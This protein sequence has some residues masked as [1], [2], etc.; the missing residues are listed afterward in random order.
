[1]ARA[2]SAIDSIIAQGLAAPE[3]AAL[4]PLLR[5]MGGA[6]SNLTS[7][8]EGAANAIWLVRE[9][10]SGRPAEFCWVAV[11]LLIHVSKSRLREGVEWPLIAWIFAGADHLVR[12]A[13]FLLSMPATTVPRVE[14]VLADPDRSMASAA[15]LILA[16]APAVATSFMSPI[17]DRLHE[18]IQAP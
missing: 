18:I 2:F 16:L 10:L 14:A 7:G 12:N 13:R 4:H 3:I 11:W 6:V 1:M 9:D 17:H 15:R 8:R 5:R